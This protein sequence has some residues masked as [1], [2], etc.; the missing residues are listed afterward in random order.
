MKKRNLLV[1]LL[2]CASILGTQSAPAHAFQSQVMVLVKENEDKESKG[3]HAA[4]Q[5][6]VLDITLNGKPKDPEGRMVKWTAY[7][8]DQKSGAVV[9]MESGEAKVNLSSG[10]TQKI[11][12]KKITTS[13]T[14]KYTKS[15]S[16]GGG[17]GRSRRVKY[18]EVPGSGVKYYGY[19]VQVFDGENVVGEKFDPKKIEADK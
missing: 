19:G 16:S 12:T 3:N 18:T 15:S 1:W 7:G 4:S 11:S 14:E 13:Y 5:T 2:A 9:S 17:R 6:V 8:K 10:A